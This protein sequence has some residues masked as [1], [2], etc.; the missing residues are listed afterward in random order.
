MGKFEESKREKKKRLRVLLAAAECAPFVKVGGLADV[1]GSL[2]K[3]LYKLGVD[4]RVVIPKYK[5]ISNSKFQIPRKS[6]IP[7]SKFKTDFGGVEEITVHES[8]LPDS[9]VP[10]YFL[11]N[12][13]YLSGGGV[14]F[15]K[16]AFVSGQEEIKRFAF[17]S[18][19]IVNFQFSISNFQPDIIHCNDWHTGLIPGLLWYGPRP[20]PSSTPRR[21]PPGSRGRRGGVSSRSGSNL[22]PPLNAPAS[23][24]SSYARS[25]SQLASAVVS[26]GAG[27][28]AARPA[29]VFTIHNLANQGF[30]DLSL[31]KNLDSI[32]SES[33][34]LR[35]DAEDDNLDLMLQGI[36]AADV[37]ST[38]S[39]T[40]AKEI[41]TPEF[42]EGLYQVLKAR[43]ARLY[44]ILNGIDYEVWNPETDPKIEF[45]YGLK[46]GLAGKVGNKIYLQRE[47]GLSVSSEVPLIG[48]VNRLAEQKGIDILLEAL[49]GILSFGA[50][51]VILGVGDEEFENQL[52]TLNSQLSPHKNFAFIN[53]FDEE[54]AHRIYAGADLFLMPSKFEPCGLVQIIAMRY[55]ALPIV[56]ATGGLKDTVVD[57]QTGFVFEEYSAEALL[58]AV[59]RAVGRF[60]VENTQFRQ[61]VG[62]AMR[63]DFS[64][65][66]SAREY[67]NLYQKAVEYKRE[68]LSV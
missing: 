25:L 30:S 49:K 18:K 11:E 5:E 46:E 35:W 36:T 45:N 31:L 65:D 68:A 2:P 26:S 64:W 63:Q 40:Y 1:I 17:F 28:R 51:L 41:L 37:I 13:R 20:A 34:L 48:M 55:G 14:Y 67:L 38:V 53:R 32:T 47:L 33:K 9:E 10:I 58:E 7:N 21:N 8:T 52:S 60:G 16:D 23:R 3:A 56:R 43:E 39:P 4:V 57:S 22:P 19:A 50:Q 54:W 12:Q 59:E 15:S 44:G 42:G 27:L 6:Q 62:R 29:T 66:T 24:F 61:M